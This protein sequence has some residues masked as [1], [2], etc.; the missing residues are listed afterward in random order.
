VDLLDVLHGHEEEHDQGSAVGA[1]EA[2]SGEAEAGV[3]R[4][5][6]AYKAS[7]RAVRA[8]PIS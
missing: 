3:G 4:G 1:E 7:G 5:G 2:G 6:F 8:I